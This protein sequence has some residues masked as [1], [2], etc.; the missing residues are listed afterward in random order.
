M[1]HEHFATVVIRSFLL[2]PARQYAGV[3]ATARLVFSTPQG[4]LHELGAVIAMALASE[5]GWHALYLAQACPRRKLPDRIPKSGA[6]RGAEHHISRRRPE[7]GRRVA[8]SSP[9]SSGKHRN[10]RR[11]ARCRKMPEGKIAALSPSAIAG[12][13]TQRD[14][15]PQIDKCLT[16]LRHLRKH[17]FSH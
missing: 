16:H 12:R 17:T 1:A 11:R 5:Q 13:I 6:S 3:N 7:R 2:N 10:H 4:Q 8:R 14:W 15:M 9:F